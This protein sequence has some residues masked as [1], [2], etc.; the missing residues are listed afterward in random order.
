MVL[1]ISKESTMGADF[2]LVCYAYQLF[3]F[4]VQRAIVSFSP[5]FFHHILLSWIAL[6]KQVYLPLLILFLHRF[7]LFVTFLMH[8]TYVLDEI[9]RIQMPHYF[10]VAT[11]TASDLFLTISKNII[12]TGW[13]YIM[14]ARGHHFGDFPTRKF[15]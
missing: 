1:V 15:A 4:F 9:A 3:L 5:H 11:E 7:Y 10:Y 2:L 13:A 6:F 8:E 14:Y 12:Q